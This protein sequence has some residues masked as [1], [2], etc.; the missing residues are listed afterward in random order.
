MGKQKTRYSIIQYIRGGR[1]YRVHS[2][3]FYKSPW[4]DTTRLKHAKATLQHCR[5]N[6]PNIKFRLMKT[7]TKSDVLDY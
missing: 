2:F 1:E 5:K 4:T 6:W 7:V 3:R